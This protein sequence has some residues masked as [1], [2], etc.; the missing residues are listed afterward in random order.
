MPC[1]SVSKARLF[2]DVAV[3]LPIRETADWKL[4][5]DHRIL[6]NAVV[7]A[8]GELNDQQ[9]LS[10]LKDLAARIGTFRFDDGAGV[11]VPELILN[12]EFSELLRRVASELED[13][14]SMPARRPTPIRPPVVNKQ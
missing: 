7:H 6:R 1:P 11:I 14:W 12:A 3:G 10:R 2:L 9:Q 5:A 8:Q 4:L 13:A